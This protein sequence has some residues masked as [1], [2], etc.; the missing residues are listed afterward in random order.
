MQRENDRDETLDRQGHHHDN[1]E[2]REVSSHA[3]RGADVR[4]PHHF[5]LGDRLGHLQRDQGDRED[6]DALNPGYSPNR[7]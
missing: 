5:L 3:R 2:P 7:H 1:Q 6:P 4:A